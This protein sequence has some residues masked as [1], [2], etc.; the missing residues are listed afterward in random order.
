M[1]FFYIN[2]YRTFENYLLTFT[3]DLDG[4]IVL[5]LHPDEATE[6]II[7]TSLN[8]KL[9]F[10]VIPC[11]VLPQLFPN[12]RH[13]KTKKL[14]KKLGSFIEYLI[15]LGQESGYNI[16]ITELPFEGRNT[17]LYMSSTDYL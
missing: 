10:A 17:V 4:S 11:C 8:N 3:D 16:K 2:I 12:R 5:G 6:A 13:K 7:S 9:P 1:L 15:D 14:I